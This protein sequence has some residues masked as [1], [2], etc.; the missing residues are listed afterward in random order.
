M[1]RFDKYAL[2]EKSNRQE[3]NALLSTYE[4]NVSWP[5]VLAASGVEADSGWTNESSQRLG[6]EDFSSEETE[7][8]V[9][10]RP[11]PPCPPPSA[12]TRRR[13]RM[14]AMMSSA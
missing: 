8:K 1:Q 9:G 10:P 4:D 2:I 13:N 12:T 14:T 6:A 5:R 11:I 3:P 7:S